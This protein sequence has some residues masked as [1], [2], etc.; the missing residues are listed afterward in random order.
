M[1]EQVAGISEAKISKHGEGISERSGAEEHEGQSPHDG[2]KQAASN[3]CKDI[4]RVQVEGFVKNGEENAVQESPNY[5]IPR[6]AVPQ[7][8]DSKYND[9]IDIRSDFSF[10]I[11]SKREIEIVAEPVGE[12][13]MPSCPKILE[14]SRQIR[15]VEISAQFE[16]EQTGCADGDLRIGRKVKVELEGEENGGHQG[17]KTVHVGDIPINGI[18]INGQPVSNYNFFEKSDGNKEQSLRAES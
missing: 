5:K 2:D 4:L 14:G 7:S 6:G 12:R 9:D 18:D 10:P 1:V 16:P 11:A 13:D 17:G 8:T 3:F 15:F